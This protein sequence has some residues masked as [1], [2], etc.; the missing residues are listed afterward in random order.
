MSLFDNF[1]VSSDFLNVLIR[2]CPFLC[3]MAKDPRYLKVKKFILKGAVDSFEQ[4]HDLVPKTIVA[5]DLGMHHYTYDD[6]LENPIDFTFKN[7]YELAFLCEVEPIL[8][9]DLVREAI[10]SKIKGKK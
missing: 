9:I 8:I 6:R 7:I 2:L 1:Y 10:D 5:K 4:I 3:K